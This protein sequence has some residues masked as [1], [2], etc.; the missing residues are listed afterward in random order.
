MKLATQHLKFNIFK[1]KLLN[2][3]TPAIGW[4]IFIFI[5]SIVP[6]KDIPEIESPWDLI[7]MD[8][9][10]HMALYAVLIWQILRGYRYKSHTEG[11][12]HESK[13]YLF[14]GFLI[15]LCAC[16]Y[17]FF[18]EWIQEHYCQDRG[19]EWYDGIANTIGAFV[20][21]VIFYYFQRKRQIMIR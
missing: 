3:Y 4:G 5:L 16:L 2:N 17:G 8:K 6:G 13:H 15:V 11:K 21:S 12:F 10:V 7:K 14:F 20:A 1:M 18:M 19:F 9:L